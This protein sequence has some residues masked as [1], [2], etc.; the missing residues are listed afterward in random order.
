MPLGDSSLNLLCRQGRALPLRACYVAS[1]RCG[2]PLQ[3]LTQ[4]IAQSST[5]TGRCATSNNPVQATEGGAAR[6]R[7]ISFY[8]LNSVGVQHKSLEVELLRSSFLGSC[9]SIPRAALRLHGVITCITPSGVT[10]WKY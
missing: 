5:H 4:G 6:G 2:V 7:A 9:I 8:P 1:M 3:S 10:E